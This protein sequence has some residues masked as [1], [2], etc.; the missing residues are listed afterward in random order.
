MEKQELTHVKETFEEAI[1]YQ[2][3][4]PCYN[5]IVKAM[6]FNATIDESDNYEIIL[7]QPCDEGYEWI[8]LID[9][10]C[11]FIFTYKELPDGLLGIEDIKT[12]IRLREKENTEDL[13]RRFNVEVTEGMDFYD[14]QDFIIQLDELFDY[15]YEDEVMQDFIIPFIEDQTKML[16]EKK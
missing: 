3:D 1:K 11:Y 9:S 7:Y 14:F 8:C 12:I 2:G 15:F 16:K 4:P 10:L 6:C 13:A 5:C